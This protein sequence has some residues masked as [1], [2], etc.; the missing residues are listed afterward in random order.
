[1]EL[2]VQAARWLNTVVNVLEDPQL[3]AN[4][5][6]LEGLRPNMEAVLK[7]AVSQYSLHIRSDVVLYA[8]H[9]TRS[10]SLRGIVQGEE[11][12]LERCGSPRT[13]RIYRNYVTP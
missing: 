6:E 12:C 2:A 11:Q 10:R 8:G 4:H 5:S 9:W 1:M 7:C 13:R 3:K